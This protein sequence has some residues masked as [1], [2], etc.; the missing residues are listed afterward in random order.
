VPVGAGITRVLFHYGFMETPDIMEGLG[1]ACRLPELQGID[2]ENITYYFRRVMVIAGEEA[3]GMAVW[4]KDAPQRQPASGVFR[5]PAQ[6]G[7]GGWPR[8]RNLVPTAITVS[9]ATLRN[10][11]LGS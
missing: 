7:R 11:P 9:T 5:S 4:R 1:L 10:C 3:S 8:S 6:S 2:P